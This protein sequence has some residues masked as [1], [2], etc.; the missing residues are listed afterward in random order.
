MLMDYQGLNE[1]YFPITR[2]IPDMGKTIKEVQLAKG[3]LYTL[4]S[5]LMPPFPI[6]IRESSQNNTHSG[7]LGSGVCLL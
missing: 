7:G 2:A 1:V 4:Q 5:H 3:D 6:V